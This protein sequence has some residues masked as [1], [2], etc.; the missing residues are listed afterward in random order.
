MHSLN[1]ISGQAENFI[2]ITFQITI[3]IFSIFFVVLTTEKIHNIIIFLNKH[4]LFTNS[5]IHVFF[6]SR[7]I[8]TERSKI[9][10]TFSRQTPFIYEI[11]D[12]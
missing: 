4:N 11:N 1:Y 5:T 2:Q 3:D 8:L 6:F 9:L 10:Y 12:R 7:R